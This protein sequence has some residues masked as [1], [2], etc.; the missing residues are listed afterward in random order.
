MK[1]LG[2]TEDFILWECSHVKII[3]YLNSVFWWKTI[4]AGID[5]ATGE[6]AKTPGAPPAAGAPAPAPAPGP[7]PPGGSANPGTTNDGS[8]RES[9]KVEMKSGDA[10]AN[11]LGGPS[12]KPSLSSQMGAGGGAQPFTKKPPH[13]EG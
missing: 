10:F 8:W 9:N 13:G 5:P 6:K 4:E 3:R 1:E 11:F 12:A 2:F 7:R